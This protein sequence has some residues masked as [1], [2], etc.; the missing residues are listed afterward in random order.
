MMLSRSQVDRV[1]QR[2]KSGDVDGDVIQTLEKYRGEFSGMYKVVE[3]LLRDRLGYQVTGRPAKSTVAITEKL[4]R[5][6]IRLSQI[7]DIAGCRVIVPT[8]VAQDL[9]GNSLSVFFDDIVLDDKRDV[10]TNGYRA[11]H[12]IPKIEG[13]SIEIQIRTDLQHVWADTSER[14]ADIHG[15]EVKYGK[16]AER[17]VNYLSR[18][19]AAVAKFETAGRRNLEFN[20]LSSGA[21]AG[22]DLSSRKKERKKYAD[23]LRMASYDLK[24]IINEAAGYLVK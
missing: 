14:L 7:Q 6:S 4:R 11:L 19:S 1:G 13:R 20:R 5:Q 22:G 3:T 24:L 21:E 12:A 8:V 10:P 16:G 23:A 2:L 17:V 15:Q 18:F 9:L